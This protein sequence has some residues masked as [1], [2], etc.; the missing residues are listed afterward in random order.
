MTPAEHDLIIAFFARQ[1]QLIKTVMQI[2][3]SKEYITD[4]DFAAF[5]FAVTGDIVSNAGLLASTKAEYLELAKALGVET[6]LKTP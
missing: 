4:D 3:K 5:E 2:L 1:L 6:G